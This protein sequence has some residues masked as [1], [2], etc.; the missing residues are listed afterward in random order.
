MILNTFNLVFKT[1]YRIL[2]LGAVMHNAAITV[3]LYLLKCNWWHKL[4]GGFFF[5]YQFWNK[6]FV[7][8]ANKLNSLWIRK[9]KW[10]SHISPPPPPLFDNA[11]HNVWQIMHQIHQNNLIKDITQTKN[12]Q[13]EL[14]QNCTIHSFVFL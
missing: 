7:L 8:N 10:A 1:F 13:A 3:L 2:I 14:L 5:F 4:L 6:C 11:T 9:K 12:H